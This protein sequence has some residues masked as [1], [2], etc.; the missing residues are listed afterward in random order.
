MITYRSRGR[1]RLMLRRC[2]ATPNPRFGMI[3]PPRVAPSSSHLPA[4]QQQAGAVGQAAST[5]T[6]TTNHASNASRPSSTGNEY[7]T[8]LE[9]R[10]VQML[11]DGR[12][13]V[14][15]WGAWRFRIVERG[16]LD[17]YV[18]ARVERV[19][20]WEEEDVVFVEETQEEAGSSRP[21]KQRTIAQLMEICHD[22]LNELRQGTPWVVQRLDQNFVPMPA[23]PS[24]FSFWMGA[25]SLQFLF[26]LF[27]SDC[28]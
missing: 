11:A 25:V 28:R 17:G 18:V 5:S 16:T 9:I 26:S 23:D 4:S 1:Y 3:P 24:N 20:D 15:T 7:G 10:R 27:C 22:F 14:E 6:A 19:D 8:M 21:D 13:V 2:L 12:A